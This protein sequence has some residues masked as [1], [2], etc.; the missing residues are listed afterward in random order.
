VLDHY[1]EVLSRKPGAF[2]G[3]T[4]LAA[5]RTSGVGRSK[6][7]RDEDGVEPSTSAGSRHECHRSDVRGRPVGRKS[8]VRGGPSGLS[9]PL[10]GQ[11]LRAMDWLTAALKLSVRQ[12]AQLDSVNHKLVDIFRFAIENRF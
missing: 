7:P 12:S 10:I 4:A 11:V 6:S 9:P 1:L 2:S 8:Q 5:A 3:S